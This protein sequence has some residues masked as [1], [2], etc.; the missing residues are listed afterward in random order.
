MALG[1]PAR[2]H[3]ASAG[4]EVVVARPQP[5]LAPQYALAWSVSRHRLLASCPRAV[6]WQYHGCR[7]A[8]FAETRT[9]IARDLDTLR[10]YMRD[11]VRAIPKPKD[12]WPMTSDPGTCRRCRFRRLCETD[13]AGAKT[14]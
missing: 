3:P 13:R 14:E 4:P 11:P 1:G 10:G 8:L 5:P 6:F 7:A 2:P 9:T 12:D